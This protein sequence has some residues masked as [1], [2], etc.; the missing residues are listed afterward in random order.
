MVRNTTRPGS[1]LGPFQHAAPAF[2]SLDRGLGQAITNDLLFKRQ[3]SNS[4]VRRLGEYSLSE[5]RGTSQQRQR[6]EAAKL[7]FPELEGQDPLDRYFDDVAALARPP[8]PQLD[9]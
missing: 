5:L 6:F 4:R 2:H 7:M 3:R 1:F 9:R 8:W